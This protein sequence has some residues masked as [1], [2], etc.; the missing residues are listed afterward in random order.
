M[1]ILFQ[2]KQLTGCNV[3]ADNV[4]VTI[5]TFINVNLKLYLFV[6]MILWESE[7][8]TKS[9]LWCATTTC[10]SKKSMIVLFAVSFR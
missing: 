10:H 6:G 7:S 8:W 4:N 9:D 1:V 2:G 5:I 3:I